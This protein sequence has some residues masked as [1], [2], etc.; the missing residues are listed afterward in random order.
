MVE[1]VG[2]LPS[3]L[4]WLA[5]RHAE[6]C[7][8]PLGVARQYIA[9]LAISARSQDATGLDADDEAPDARDARATSVK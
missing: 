3:F 1:R 9:A 4:I 5:R 7:G 2:P 8:L 6:R